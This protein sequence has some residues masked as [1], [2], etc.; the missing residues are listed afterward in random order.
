MGSASRGF[1]PQTLQSHTTHFFSNCL[2]DSSL[3]EIGRGVPLSR[4]SAKLRAT[5]HITDSD[6]LLVDDFVG[7]KELIKKLK[8]MLQVAGSGV[9]ATQLFSRGT[10]LVYY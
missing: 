2:K 8:I 9:F 1:P 3:F 6:S 5:F 4:G 7:T 10:I